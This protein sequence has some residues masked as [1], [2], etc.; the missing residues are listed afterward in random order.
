MP[1]LVSQITFDSLSETK[2]GPFGAH[3]VK[4]QLSYLDIV[5]ILRFHQTPMGQNVWNKVGPAEAHQ[6]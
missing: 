5:A 4:N 6:A 2:L 3:Q 1:P